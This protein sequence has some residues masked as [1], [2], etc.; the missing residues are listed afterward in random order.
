[1]PDNIMLQRIRAEYLEMPGMRL[2]APQ[3]QRLCSIEP[4]VCQW[5]LDALIDAKFLRVT[6]GGQ[7]C[8]V[9]EGDMPRPQPAKAEH[10]NRPATTNER[11]GHSRFEHLCK[12][13][14]LRHRFRRVMRV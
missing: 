2:T 5:A 10:P 11:M 8:R 14:S 12:T 9:T 3:V 13:H 7:Y 1:M 4:T 6:P